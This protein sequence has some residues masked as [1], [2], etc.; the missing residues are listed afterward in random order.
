MTNNFNALVNPRA[1]QAYENLRSRILQA[2][3]RPGSF[4]SAQALAKDIGVSRT[5]VREA[6]R[7]L[8]IEGLVTIVPKAGAVVT[9]LNAGQL[10]ELQDYRMALEIYAVEEVAERW[11]AADLREM[12]SVL[13]TEHREIEAFAAD[14]GNPV[15]SRIVAENDR[16]FHR[17]LIDASGNHLF[18][19]R[20]DRT[21]ILQD[22]HGSGQGLRQHPAESVRE[23]RAAWREHE[24]IVE[25]VK[26]RDSEGARQAMKL[27]LSNRARRIHS[28]DAE[29]AA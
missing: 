9:I 17:T 18:R 29:R 13:E 6:L 11:G 2:E 3:L 21:L 27:H 23:A 14:P 1:A 4:L 22:T 20:L 12:A 24:D 10:R 15:L 8:E 16:R 26:S 19:E 5:S 25:K 28:P 7:E